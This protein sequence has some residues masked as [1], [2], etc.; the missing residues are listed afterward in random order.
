MERQILLEV[1]VKYIGL[2]FGLH[3]KI[4]FYTL[5]I[6]ELE[7][8]GVFDS[9][10]QGYMHLQQPISLNASYLDVSSWYEK[11]PDLSCIPQICGLIFCHVYVISRQCIIFGNLQD[12]TMNAQKVI[13]V[14]N[15]KF[16][17]RIILVRIVRLLED[18]RQVIDWKNLLSIF[19]ELSDFLK[20]RD[21]W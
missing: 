10:T 4:S 6:T 8:A 2:L 16:L 12:A 19:K 17:F 20:I 14:K 9:T 21:R 11:S 3:K 5:Q 7:S 1:M 13:D 15:W 18:Q